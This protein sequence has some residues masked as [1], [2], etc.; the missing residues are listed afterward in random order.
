MKFIFWFIGLW[1]AREVFH[2][3]S[4]P[5]YLWLYK[6]SIDILNDLSRL[7]Y[8]RMFNSIWHMKMHIV[9][10]RIVLCI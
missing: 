5:R 7:E 8:D 9:N 1:N 6:I 2:N 4:N 3:T 10:N